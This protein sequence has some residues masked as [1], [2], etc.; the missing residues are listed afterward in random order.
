MQKEQW[1][2]YL[3]ADIITFC[4]LS[5][6]FDCTIFLLLTCA[7]CQFWQPLKAFEWNTQDSFLCQI[8]CFLCQL[9]GISASSVTLT[10]SSLQALDWS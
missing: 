9:N 6:V 8:T 2:R 3:I 10:A 4:Q 1:N 5:I 7:V